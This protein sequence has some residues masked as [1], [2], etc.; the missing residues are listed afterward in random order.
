MKYEIKNRLWIETDGEIL[1]GTGRVHLLKAIEKTGS[2]SQAA[3]SINMSYKKAWTLM[4]QVN[5]RAK[6]PVIATSIGGTK[7]GG[8][9]L[10]SYGRELIVAYDTINLNCEEFLKEQLAELTL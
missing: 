1:L 5:S 2:L 9:T 8:T 3:L 10:T 4:N 6:K 7:G